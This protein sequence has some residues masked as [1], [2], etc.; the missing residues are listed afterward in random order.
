M[1]GTKI[2]WAD[3]TWNPVW[4]CRNECPYCYARKIAKRF[5]RI[6]A[7]RDDFEP[8]FIERNFKV[9]FPKKPSWIF[10]NSMSDIAYWTHSWVDSVVE[11]IEHHP[12]H[13]FLFLTKNPESYVRLQQSRLEYCGAHRVTALCG[14]PDNCYLGV[15]WTGIGEIPA[16]D[17]RVG[18]KRF[19]SIE[20]LLDNPRAFTVREAM[21]FD[22]VI[23]GAETG[24]RIGKRTPSIEWIESIRQACNIARVPIF[25]KGS[26]ALIVKD[27]VRAWPEKLA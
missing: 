27:M 20:P 26:L 10:V 7:G 11:R 2:D 8:T 3:T 23:I 9:R 17:P 5:G 25:M 6:I 4:G 14:W 12:E 15:S 13:R 19:I 24:N 18:G 21:R 1:K 22:W 16:I